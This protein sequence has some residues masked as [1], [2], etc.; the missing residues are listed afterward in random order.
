MGNDQV[1]RFNQTLLKMLGTLEHYQ[2]SDWKAYIPTPTTPYFMI[3]PA[4]LGLNSD[5]LSSTN[6]TEYVRKIRDLL[7]FADKKAHELSM[8]SSAKHKL[9][10][11][12]R[13]RSSVLRLGDR[14]LVK[15]AGVRGKCK[16]ADRS[17]N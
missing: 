5:S 15:N 13:V 2:K 8:K 6:Q 4:F 3:V 7:R 10:Y 16:L 11:D 9:N 17:S 12:L 14:V 1:Q